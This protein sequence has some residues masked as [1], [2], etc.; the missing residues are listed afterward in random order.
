MGANL[1]YIEDFFERPYLISIGNIEPKKNQER[2]LKALIELHNEGL[3]VN[4]VLIGN[5]GWKSDAVMGI[6]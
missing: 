2:L 6:I 4:L 1:R 5:N 3:T